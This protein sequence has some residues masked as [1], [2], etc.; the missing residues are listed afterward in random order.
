MITTQSLTQQEA[1]ARDAFIDRLLQAVGGAFDIFT[2]YIGYKLGLYDALQRSGPLTA[3]GLAARTDTEERYIR[4]WLEQQTVAGILQ[5]DHPVAGDD[6]R[7]FSLPRAHAE[8]LTDRDSPNYV[9]PLAPMIAGAVRPIQQVLQAFQHGGGVAYQEYGADFREGQGG[10]NRVTFLTDLP[11]EWLPSLQGLHARLQA[12]P[13]ARV[14]DLGTGAGWSS[15]GIAQAYPK[16]HVDGFDL[17][18]PSVEMARKN[19]RQAGLNGRVH[20]HVRD[21]ADPDLNGR[22]DL[23]TAFECIHD[24]PDP[25]GALAT[26]RRLAAED[27][28]VIVVDERVGDSFTPNGNDIE[29]MMYGWSVLHCLP[30]GMADHPS[31]GTGTVMR[32]DTLRNYALQ[33]GFS[34]VDV[35]PIEN[36]FFRIYRLHK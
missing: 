2:V 5:V 8:V 3:G 33:A 29:W 6:Q 14:A 25:V 28:V 22:Y 21:A 23:V 15:I 32:T 13:G 31:V 12:D 30:V 35:L 20:F 17:D 11:N 9:A 36:F 10:I 19:A 34:A 18:E 16:V 1:A 26:M 4:E 7:R 24:L 27:G